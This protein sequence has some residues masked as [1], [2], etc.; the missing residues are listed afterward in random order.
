MEFVMP[1]NIETQ[2]NPEFWLAIA[3]SYQAE[4]YTDAIKDAMSVVTETL[5]DKSG[6]DGDGTEL[7]GKALGFGKDNSPRIRIN[8]LQTETEKNIQIGLQEILRGLYSLVRNPRIHEK[9]DDSKKT[10]D[11]IITFIDYLLGFLVVC[12]SLWTF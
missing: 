4:N 10:A 2:I 8:K 1:T 9:V 11:T 7:V 6:L 3:N 5:R 12:Q